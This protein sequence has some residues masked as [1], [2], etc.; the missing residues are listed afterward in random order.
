[1][2]ERVMERDVSLSVLLLKTRKTKYV[3]H[4]VLK[5][6]PHDKSAGSKVSE[7]VRS[8][9]RRQYCVEVRWPQ[10]SRQYMGSKCTKRS[11]FDFFWVDIVPSLAA[12]YSCQAATHRF[13]VIVRDTQPL[14][15]SWLTFRSKSFMIDSE[16]GS[17]TIFLRKSWIEGVICGSKL[18]SW[19]FFLRAL[20]AESILCTPHFHSPALSCHHP[21]NTMCFSRSQPLTLIRPDLRWDNRPSWEMLS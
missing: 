17:H 6:P 7:W 19:K 14:S 18:K 16:L 2:I 3:H 15:C 11:L 20:C 8:I 5:R 9:G 1:M 4:R 21:P 13:S 12:A 10:I